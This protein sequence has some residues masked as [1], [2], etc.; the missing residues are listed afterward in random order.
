VPFGCK[1]ATERCLLAAPGCDFMMSDSFSPLP[2]LSLPVSEARAPYNMLAKW[3]YA[4]AP[5]LCA[6]SIVNMH[7]E[8]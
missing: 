6:V 7:N 1:E 5:P 3:V 8:E 4:A 2:K